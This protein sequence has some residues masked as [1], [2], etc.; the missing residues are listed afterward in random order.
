MAEQRPTLAVSSAPIWRQRLG[1]VFAAARFAGADGLEVLV[2]QDSE[3]QTPATLERLAQR[4]DLPI[5]AIHAPLLLLTR[6]VYTADP[7]EKIKR[8]L[9]LARTLDVGTI[10]LHPPYLWQ[11]R[12]S[13]WIIHELQDALAGSHTTVTMENMYPVHLGGRRMRFHRYGSLDSLSRFPHLTLDTSHLAVAEEDIVGA[14]RRL[15]DRVVHIHLSDNR[16]KGRDSHAP[17]GEGVLPLAEF[18]RG[19]D[20]SSLRSICNFPCGGRSQRPL[21]LWLSPS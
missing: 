21:P 4:H 15:A 20:H 3:T 13:L 17:I 11:M 16:G 18:V 10:V 6:R 14:Y 9:D 2:T 5:V 1:E 12:Y 7:V 19:L 8:T